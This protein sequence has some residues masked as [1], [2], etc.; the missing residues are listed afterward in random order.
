MTTRRQVI[1]VLKRL[2]F[3]GELLEEPSRRVRAWSN[4]AWALRQA[5]GDLHELAEAGQLTEIRGIGARLAD[6]IKRVLDDE[7]VP[8][9]VELEAKLPDGLLE[10]RHV[11]GLGPKKV[12]LLWDELGIGSLSELEYACHENRL[13]E[14]KGFGERTQAKVLESLQQ[15]RAWA[16]R[17]RLDQALDTATR[18]A[19]A[20]LA[21]PAITRVELVGQARRGHETV[22]GVEL[23]VLTELDGL[24]LL[25]ELTDLIDEAFVEPEAV[26]GTVGGQPIRVYAAAEEGR[27][28][29]HMLRRIGSE[30]HLELLREHARSKGYELREDGLFKGD[31]LVPCGRD[32]DVYFAL[33][34]SPTAAERREPGVPLVHAGASEPALV[35][36]SDLEGALHNHTTESDGTHS[37]EEMR[38]A[39]IARGLRY[40]AITEHSQTAAYAGG[41]E[42]ERLRAQA[43]AIRALNEDPSSF[44]CTL[45]HGV[46][47]D[48]LGD[49]GL[50]YPPEVL[51]ELDLVIASVHNRLRQS[52]QDMSRRMAA[53]A[54]NPWTTCIGH[55]TGRLLLGRPPSEYDVEAMLDTCAVTGCAVE[56]NSHPQRLDFEPRWLAAARARGV[57]VSIAADAHSASALDHLE[58]GI[59]V[60]RRAGLTRY[61][62]LNC[63]PL[64][65]LLGWLEARRD[66]ARTDTL[67]S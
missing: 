43:A 15:V 6:I 37:L 39:A 38:D 49:G 19:R 46:E 67:R 51:A 10:L 14:L 23:L 44:E 2:A 36:R 56:L 47:S 26:A 34:L 57:M 8:E 22:E 16:G 1:E 53:A 27:F 41:L 42:V 12:K 18:V 29:A 20:L 24:D 54:R 61:D 21:E 58:Y 33:G 52:P 50:D 55:P 40:L 32:D 65:E 45:L 59:K 66:K 48:I 63:R 5:G 13:V 62:V 28:G 3:A 9:L 25:A 64:H 7:A 11:R 30:P 4:A 17:F 35:K 31:A 60:A